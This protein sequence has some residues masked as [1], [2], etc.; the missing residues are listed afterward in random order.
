MYLP[1]GRTDKDEDVMKFI[2]CEIKQNG[3]GQ[4]KT[5]IKFDVK[6]DKHI[7]LQYSTNGKKPAYLRT[8]SFFKC[9]QFQ[10]H[11][12]TNILVSSHFSVGITIVT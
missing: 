7:I 4:V 9:I 3:I 5:F 1:S 11:I 6:R 12:L 2:C 10:K 8:I